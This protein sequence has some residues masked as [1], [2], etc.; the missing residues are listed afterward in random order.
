M[1][2]IHLAGTNAKGSTA[3]YL[4]DI[5][6]IHH[7][8]GLF[9]SPHILSPLERFRIN[10]KE[11][12]PQD[13]DAYMKLERRDA[14]EHFFGVWARI[15]L[16]WFADNE[17][18]YAVIETGLG[19]RKDQTNVIDSHIQ[20]ITPISFDHTKELGD[21]IQK[22]AR[23]KCGIITWGGTVIC[24]PQQREAMDVIKKTCER[25]NA[26]LIVLD[27]KS[28]RIHS[29]DT[30]GQVFDFRYQSLYMKDAYISAV[31]PVQVQNACVAA[32]AAYELGIPADDI[33]QGLKQAYI[34]ARTQYVDGVLIDSAHNPAAMRVLAD[35]V[36]R[37][38]SKK[39]ITALCAVMED[40]DVPAIAQEIKTFANQIVCTR[41]EKNR[42]LT[43]REFAQYFDNAQPM[44]DP[45]YAFDYALELSQQKRG[46]LVVCGSFYLVPYAMNKLGLSV[47]IPPSQ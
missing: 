19:G 32:I 38:F 42:G 11:M 1:E 37:Y 43:S 46:I 22:I 47:E 18:E 30:G 6:S 5:L 31:S 7:R 12:E 34:P 20:V 39:N 21:T 14:G 10:G 8:C 9:T 40:K 41:A 3:Q 45:S 44:E 36:K 23:E 35:T 24:H 29:A 17:V 15:A 16:Q 28:I 2:Y 27:E 33:L 26:Q 25:L 13:Y 4:A